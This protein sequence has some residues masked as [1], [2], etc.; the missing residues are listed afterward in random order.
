M[1]SGLMCGLICGLRHARAQRGAPDVGRSAG[2]G[3]REST[4]TS[5]VC[6][7]RYNKPARLL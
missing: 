6:G 2:G 7:L 3:I 5:T 4:T 1:M